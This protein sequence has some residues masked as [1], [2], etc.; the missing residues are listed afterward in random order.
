ML[1]TPT[2]IIINQL[3]SRIMKHLKFN[4]I[5][6]KFLVKKNVVTSP[7]QRSTGISVV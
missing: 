1:K 4:T 7:I 5:K 3:V 6:H 2:I